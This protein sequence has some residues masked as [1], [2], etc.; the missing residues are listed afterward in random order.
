MKT[1]QGFVSNSSSSSFVLITTK[2]MLEEAKQSLTQFGKDL[3]DSVIQEP[4]KAKIFGKNCLVFW[5]EYNSEEMGS[6]LEC[7]K[8]SESE[9]D[10]LYDQWG[11][12]LDK[13]NELGGYFNENQL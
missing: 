2:E 4:S 12:F 10:T 1:R 8:Y 13:T 3:V 9:W 5:G 11:L 6:D 7:E